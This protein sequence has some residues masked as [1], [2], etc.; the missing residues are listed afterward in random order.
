[1]LVALSIQELTVTDGVVGVFDGHGIQGRN[2]ARIAT[3]SILKHLEADSRSDASSLAREWD[4]I[5]GDACVQVC[6]S[7]LDW[8]PCYPVSCCP[9]SYS[10]S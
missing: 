9:C 7:R 8:P 4:R 3:E 1:M 10:M 6:A 2:A 5:F